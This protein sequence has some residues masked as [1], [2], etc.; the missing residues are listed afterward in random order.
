MMGYCGPFKYQTDYCEKL[1]S[2]IEANLAWMEEQ[3]E[4]GE[5][6]EYWYQVGDPVLSICMYQRD[7]E[8]CTKW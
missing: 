1:K 2:Y 3:I 4:K 5:D 6:S 8:H 7:A